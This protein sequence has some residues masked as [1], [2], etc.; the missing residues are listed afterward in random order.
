MF[1]P[2]SIVVAV[3]GSANV[4][5]ANVSSANVSSAIVSLVVAIGFTIIL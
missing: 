3:V 1:L 2:Y 4:S 5:S